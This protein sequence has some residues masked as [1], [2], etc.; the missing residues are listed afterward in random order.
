MP[1][2]FPGMD[3]YLERPSLWVQ[4]H[5]SLI[6]D[7]QRF[8]T[9]L[10]RPRYNVA[11]EQHTYLTFL[12]PNEQRSGIPDILLASPIDE[13]DEDIAVATVPM[14]TRPLVS[15]L[16][17]PKVV[18]EVFLEVRDAVNQE[19]ITVIE[20][21]SPANKIGR[22]GRSQYERKRLKVLASFTNLVEIDLIRA[23][24]PF[25]MK[26]KQASDYR[27]VVSRGWQRPKADIYLFGVRE[28]IPD[29][30]IPLQEDETEPVLPLNKILHEL[31]DLGGYD[32]A[33]NY[34]QK[35]EPALAGEDAKWATQILGH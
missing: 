18:T 19:V 12:P 21:L 1:T 11:I 9:P 15:E 34:R 29:F 24:K 28:K 17:M 4:V 20:I 3:P 25:P 10:L 30:P 13:A 14:V 26:V 32:L 35:P 5:A 33:I 31:Y 6:V 27:I 2:P 23:G 16:P 22:E 7:I 8:L